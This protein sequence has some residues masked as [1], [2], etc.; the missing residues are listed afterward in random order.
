Q[1]PGGVPPHRERR[2]GQPHRGVLVAGGPCHPRSLPW[3]RRRVHRCDAREPLPRRPGRRE[4][5]RGGTPLPLADLL[6]RPADPAMRGRRL[7]GPALAGVALLASALPAQRAP[8]RS[9]LWF[10]LGRGT[11]NIRISCTTCERPTSLFGGSGF[12][13]IGGSLSRKVLL[14]LEVFS[15]LDDRFEARGTD[16]TVTLETYAVG[17]T[18]LWY[19]WSS[20]FH[21]SA[22]M[23]VAGVELALP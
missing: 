21:L 19:P 11:G 16:S 15:L 2:T 9:G 14:S 1:Q 13:R 3:R 12:L 17:P 23:G 7:L 5:L 18:V 10:E 6:L 20:G 8:L 22:G 4:Q